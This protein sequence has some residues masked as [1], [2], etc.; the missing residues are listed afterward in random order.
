MADDYDGLDVLDSAGENIGTVNRTFIDGGGA[1]RFL[2]VRQHGL[3]RKHRL[4]PADQLQETGEGIRVPY[5]REL[6]E[7]SPSYDPSDTLEGETLD[8]VQAYYA[9]EGRLSDNGGSATSDII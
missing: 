9:N 6:I 7:E 4:I 2:D 1:P 5:T 3:L 8:Q